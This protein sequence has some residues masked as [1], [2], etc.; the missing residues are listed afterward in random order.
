MSTG[1]RNVSN[2]SAKIALQNNQMERVVDTA[3]LGCIFAAG[4]YAQDEDEQLTFTQAQLGCSLAVLSRMRKKGEEIQDAEDGHGNTFHVIHGRICPF[5]RNPDWAPNVT[6]A[7]K[8]KQVRQEVTLHP[9]VVIYLDDDQTTDDV[10]ATA[11]QLNIS[12]VKPRRLYI[13]NNSETRRPSDIMKAMKE[14]P[15]P[16]RA[17]TIM[18]DKC[19][20]VRSLDVITKKCTQRFVMYFEAGFLPNCHFI[21]DIDKAL[22]DD[23]DKF[24]VLYPEDDTIN[25]LTVLRVFHKQVEG[26][27]RKTI[28][29]KAIDLCEEQ[30]CQYLAR[31]VTQIATP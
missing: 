5:W 2:P 30:Q 20:V 10:L 15:L 16:W 28:V 11:H 1:I 21:E 4:D 31:P 17:E 6:P 25:G 13:I 23:L 22:H 24:L 29:T 26:N 7:D 18:E 19:S 3:C 8:R 12:T 27:A 14:C 9:D